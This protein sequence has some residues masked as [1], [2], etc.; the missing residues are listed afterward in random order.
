MKQKQN[1]KAKRFEHIHGM[2]KPKRR[3]EKKESADESVAS[4]DVAPIHFNFKHPYEDFF[5]PVEEVTALH[6][7]IIVNSDYIE[8]ITVTHLASA[9]PMVEV[10]S[11]YQ[12]MTRRPDPVIDEKRVHILKNVYER[13]ANDLEL[14]PKLWAC[15]QSFIVFPDKIM[16]FDKSPTTEEFGQL[17]KEALRPKM[18]LP[19]R[20]PRN[21]P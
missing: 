3:P 13:I 6:H 15:E 16:A 11:P 7:M 21:E 2:M 9:P 10:L 1:R 14:K 20:K 12:E 8:K 18:P 17:A 4:R 5:K 19:D